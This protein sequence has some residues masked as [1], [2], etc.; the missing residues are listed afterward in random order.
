MSNNIV[1]FN[2]NA[3]RVMLANGQMETDAQLFTR[4]YGVNAQT[5]ILNNREA[6][7]MEPSPRV[8][9]AVE[10]LGMPVVR[11]WLQAHIFDL[12]LFSG[13]S[14][15]LTERQTA[16]I[17]DMMLGSFNLHAAE[18]VLFFAMIKNGEL[19]MPT[20]YID[21][22]VLMKA[23]RKFSNDYRGQ[24][25]ERVERSRVADDDGTPSRRNG[26]L[27][28]RD[29]NRQCRAEG[30]TVC[31]ALRIPDDLLFADDDTFLAQYEPKEFNL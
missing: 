7:I 19:D 16:Q 15:H 4:K 8:N 31:A 11:T 1:L 10:A 22:R 17:A 27:N 20:S 28:L 6:A 9:D 12:A 29:Y 3:G 23:L 18:F 21:G 24:V 26:L 2:N 25:I 13:T 5:D 30:K 14:Q